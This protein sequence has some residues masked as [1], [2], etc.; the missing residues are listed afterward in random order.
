M[1][2]AI[3]N[4]S[5]G[6]NKNPIG[7]YNKKIYRFLDNKRSTF[8]GQS[9]LIIGKN[10]NPNNT[11]IS[12]TL[13]YAS[14]SMTYINSPILSQ[15][16]DTIYNLKVAEKFADRGWSNFL[17]TFPRGTV[18][19]NVELVPGMGGQLSRSAGNCSIVL[20]TSEQGTVIKLKSGCKYKLQS[21]CIA[22]RGIVSNQDHFLR[23]LRKAGTARR[24]GI[25]PH[26]RACSKN[27]VDHP[28]GGRT[29][30]GAQPQNKNG[31]KNHI[32]TS[33]KKYNKRELISARKTRLQV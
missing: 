6:K 26:T 33:R 3:K 20:K 31:L 10:Y 5:S 4:L 29:R 1:N 24:L 21:T 11:S 22:A 19:Y 9:G 30:G 18:V 17:Y 8:P 14:G 28:L 12:L 25:R 16:Q 2:N 32:S 7:F 15:N 13:L 23:D 27:P